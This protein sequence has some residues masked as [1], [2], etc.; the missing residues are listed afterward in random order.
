MDAVRGLV[1]GSKCLVTAGLVTMC[2]LFSAANKL[3][4]AGCFRGDVSPFY[5]G[6]VAN[7]TGILTMN[8]QIEL[9]A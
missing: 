5:V 4:G 6:L 7:V 9:L 2:T 8:Q 3:I 1:G